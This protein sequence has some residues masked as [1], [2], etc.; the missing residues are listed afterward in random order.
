MK[1]VPHVGTFRRDARGNAADVWFPATA[2]TITGK[3]VDVCGGGATNDITSTGVR[4]MQQAVMPAPH[5]W[6]SA[7]IKS[8]ARWSRYGGAEE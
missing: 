5:G 3:S 4:Y 1:A 7:P 2:Y 6:D 8:E